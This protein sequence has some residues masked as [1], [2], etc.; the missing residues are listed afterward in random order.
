MHTKSATKRLRQTKK[1]T[2]R[3]RMWKQ[4]VKTMLKASRALAGSKDAHTKETITRTISTIDR[5]IQK[6]ILHRNTGARIKSRL[7][8]LMRAPAKKEI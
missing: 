3:N 5:A 7:L 1:R 6:G 4:K 2:A 8:K